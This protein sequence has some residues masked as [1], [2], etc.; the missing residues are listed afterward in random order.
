MKWVLSRKFRDGITAQSGLKYRQS[1]V[2]NEPISDP[3]LNEE[4][5]E[6]RN[7]ENIHEHNDEA[8]DFLNVI[9]MLV[10]HHGRKLTPRNES[11]TMNHN[12]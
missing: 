12:L 9:R 6:E 2:K 3:P 5:S 4:V 10:C 7:M 8:E 11:L 1:L